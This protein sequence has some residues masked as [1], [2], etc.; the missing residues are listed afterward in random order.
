MNKNNWISQLSITIRE[1]R[2]QLGLT[3]EE[4]ALYAGCSTLLITQLENQ[5][6]TIRLDKLIPILQSLGL[7]F[8]IGTG[9][10]GITT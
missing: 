10:H 5:K 1:R 4:L 6:S 7:E 9:K 3:Q 2:K 8:K